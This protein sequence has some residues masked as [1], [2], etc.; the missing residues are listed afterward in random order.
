MAV[1][2][3]VI[4]RHSQGPRPPQTEKPG[5][6]PGCGRCKAGG[7]IDYED[8]FDLTCTHARPAGGLGINRTMLLTATTS[9]ADRG[10]ERESGV[11]ADLLPADKLAWLMS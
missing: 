7:A 4:F 11:R 3:L 8:G 5:F 10:R 1:G 2:A 9:H 6:A